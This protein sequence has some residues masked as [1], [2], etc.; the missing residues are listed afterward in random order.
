MPSW[1]I[2]VRYVL[3]HWQQDG[4]Y[5]TAIEIGKINLAP[6]FTKQVLVDLSTQ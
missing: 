4:D 2:K 5:M 6:A 1:Q 3:W